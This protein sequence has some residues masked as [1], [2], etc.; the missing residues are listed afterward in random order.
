MTGTL[1]ALVGL[2]CADS[3]PGGGASFAPV[4][5]DYAREWEGTVHSLE[6]AEVL[7]G[8][9]R[10]SGGRARCAKP[11]APRAP[12]F[13]GPGGPPT[14]GLI[15]DGPR[16][17]TVLREGRLG[18]DAL[19]G[20]WKLERGRLVVCA[21]RSAGGPRPLS[22]WAGPDVFLFTLSPAAPGRR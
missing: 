1:L 15:A 11:F 8:L 13:S 17:V 18:R 20:I 6:G 21:A 14:W 2:T 9:V 16:R 10:V 7:Q 5:V 22:F 19:P 3:G 4:A 12:F